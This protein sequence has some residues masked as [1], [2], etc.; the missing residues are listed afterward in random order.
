[1]QL[2]RI[3]MVLEYVAAADRP[4]SAT[5][6]HKLTE[7]PKPTC[8]RALL[9]LAENG[10]I[11]ILRRRAAIQSAVVCAQRLCRGNP[12]SMSAKPHGHS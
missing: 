12:I 2:D 8:Y 1:M 11:E 7:I 3:M 4:V 9:K 6:L 5:E 10:F